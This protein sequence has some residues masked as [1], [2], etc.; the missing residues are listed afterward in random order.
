MPAFYCENCGKEVPPEVSSCPYCGKKFYSVRC[1]VCSFTGKAAL[2]VNGCPTCGYQG[3]DTGNGKKFQSEK[4]EKK[5]RDFPR[6]LYFGFLFFLLGGL[7]V[8]IKIYIGL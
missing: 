3:A 4:K 1:P 8:L 7:G 5:K 6:W 2:F